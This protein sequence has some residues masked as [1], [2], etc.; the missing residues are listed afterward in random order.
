MDTIMADIKAP[1]HTDGL[2]ICS[3]LFDGYLWG[4]LKMKVQLQ[5]AKQLL[6]SGEKLT[7]KCLLY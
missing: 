1:E 7:I 2:L 6:F 5:N 3:L 4:V